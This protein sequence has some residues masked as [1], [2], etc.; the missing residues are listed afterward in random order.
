ML[1][2]C[3]KDFL[4]TRWLW[5]ADAAIIVMFLIQPFGN[6][7]MVALFGAILSFTGLLAVFLL[8]DPAK[9][10]IFY[11]SLPLNRPTIVKA[12]YLLS[13]GL[14]TAAGIIV[15]G[16]V[17]P[18]R[19][20]LQATTQARPMTAA[21]ASPEFLALFILVSSFLAVLFL[22]FQHRFGFGRGMVR[23]GFAAAGIIAVGM[24]LGRVMDR[25]LKIPS[26]SPDT[27]HSPFSTI[28]PTRLLETL[29]GHLG[30]MLF[31]AAIIAFCAVLFLIA[32]RLSLAGYARRE[33]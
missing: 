20:A 4:A 33:F 1:K 16:V 6:S 31:L 23:F 18:V 22:P 3:R 13:V 30:T 29:H 9:T 8:E 21:T 25:W 12:R 19:L 7:M 28:G 17:L 2:I 5:A 26:P 27:G 15:F 24:A 11:A 10:E 32:L 14:I